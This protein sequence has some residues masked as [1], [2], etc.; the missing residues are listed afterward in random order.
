MNLG[1]MG[2]D[3]IRERGAEGSILRRKVQPRISIEMGICDL[4]G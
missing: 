1:R 2:S 4:Y 3:Q